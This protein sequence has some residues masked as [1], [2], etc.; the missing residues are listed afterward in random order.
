MAI[1]W[2]SLNNITD[3]TFN[4]SQIQDSS[5]LTNTLIDNADVVSQGYYGL[6]VMII[7]FLIM[8]VILF[9]DD[10]DIRMDIV[11]TIMISSGFT[12]IIGVIGLTL[13]IFSSFTH[14]MWFF[15]IFV[16]STI[17]VLFLKKKG[18]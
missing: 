5:G 3:I 6:G 14:V 18:L 4:L 9:K 12:T 7:M 17:A 15:V 10:D 8:M 16:A 1:D 13:N 11:R 2:N